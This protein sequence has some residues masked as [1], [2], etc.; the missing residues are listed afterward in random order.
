MKKTADVQSLPQ[1]ISIA[2]SRRH[3]LKCPES[4]SKTYCKPG[5]IFQRNHSWKRNWRG[6][7]KADVWNV[8]HHLIPSIWP[9]AIPANETSKVMI[10]P[11]VI[12]WTLLYCFGFEKSRQNF[13]VKQWQNLL[14]VKNN[15]LVLTVIMA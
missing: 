13:T 4:H 12:R 1:N 2:I 9:I 14:N 15:V 7:D 8:P 6:N 5:R 3:D 10:I 11:P